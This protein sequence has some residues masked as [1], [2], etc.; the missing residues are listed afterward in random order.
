VLSYYVSLFSEFR[1]VMS[2]AK[3]CSVRLGLRLLVGERG[4]CLIYVIC[5]CLSMVV[6]NTYSVVFLF[7]L[8][9]F[10]VPYVASFSDCFCPFGILSRLYSR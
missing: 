8:S 9:S 4:S 7:S 2:G 1:V 3:R 10:C 5:V 6:S